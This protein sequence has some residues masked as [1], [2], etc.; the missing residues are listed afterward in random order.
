MSENIALTQTGSADLQVLADLYEQLAGAGN[1]N[2]GAADIQIPYMGIIQ[3]SNDELKPTHAK[4]I[5]GAAIGMIF[6]N[7][8]GELYDGGE[9]VIG[10]S[11]FYDRVVN[12][13]RPKTSGGGIVERHALDS[14]VFKKAAKN[15][16]GKP[17]SVARGFALV[18]TA[19]HSFL[20]LLPS[21]VTRKTVISMKS[22]QHKPSKRWNSLIENLSIPVN[23]KEIN[24]PRF[25]QVF[26]LTT[27][28][29]S[30][31][32]GDSYNWGIQFIST[33]KD[34][35]LFQLAM[36]YH[37]EAKA[38]GIPA[39]ADEAPAANNDDSG[40]TGTSTDVPF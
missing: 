11:C 4:Y 39:S 26:K 10:I 23:G 15:E 8:T 1:E 6:N 9:G 34:R 25:A 35:A 31:T 33:V 30:H 37:A 14:E 5:K 20:Q 29:Q 18:D 3:A 38:K 19:Y 12:E 24:P 7:L 13:W 40:D 17:I 2:V 32:D 27:V 16:K 28:T 22:T 21:G 36:Q